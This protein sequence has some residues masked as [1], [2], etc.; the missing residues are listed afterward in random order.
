[1]EIQNQREEQLEGLRRK[2]EVFVQVRRENS[3][4]IVDWFVFLFRA[5]IIKY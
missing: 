2:R 1:M 5:K 4:N 3:N